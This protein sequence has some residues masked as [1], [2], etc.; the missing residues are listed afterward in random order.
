MLL[1][2]THVH[3]PEN[4]PGVK[5]EESGR[6]FVQSLSEEAALGKRVKIVGSYVAPS[7]HSIWLVLE[8]ASLQSVKNFI[9]DSLATVGSSRII[10]VM[11]I[12]QALGG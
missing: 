7:E 4:C 10:P 2:V 8:A 6:K 5:S 11:T 9:F 3:N 1:L 12:R